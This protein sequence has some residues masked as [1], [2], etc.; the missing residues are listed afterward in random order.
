MF[1]DP[2]KRHTLQTSL[3]RHVVAVHTVTCRTVLCLPWWTS[4]ISA[5]GNS[6]CGMLSL[7]TRT[8]SWTCRFGLGFCHFWR[9]CSLGIQN[10]LG[11]AVFV[12]A[13]WSWI[14]VARANSASEVPGHW[15]H[16]FDGSRDD[17]WESFPLL[18]WTL[19]VFCRLQDLSC[20][21]NHP[22]Q[23]ASCMACRWWVKVPFSVVSTQGILNSS[24]DIHC[25]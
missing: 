18:S 8:R 11:T 5:I 19:E 20:H 3:R 25:R 24:L 13:G 1:A 7:T 17:H 6:S 9:S 15:G 22:F 2:S 21:A 23:H 14:E 16:Y 12:C 4:S 10:S